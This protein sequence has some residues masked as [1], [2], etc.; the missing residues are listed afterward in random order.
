MAR[1]AVCLKKACF[2]VAGLT[3]WFIFDFLAVVM[4]CLSG[5]G[6]ANFCVF[7]RFVIVAS[8]NRQDLLFVSRLLGA[9]LSVKVHQRIRAEGQIS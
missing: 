2:P 7:L 5:V 1:N 9:A 4:T 3:V 6:L 8:M